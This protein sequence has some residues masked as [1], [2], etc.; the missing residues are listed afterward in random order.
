MTSSSDDIT[1]DDI[2]ELWWCVRFVVGLLSWRAHFPSPPRPVPGLLTGLPC[3]NAVVRRQVGVSCTMAF[4]SSFEPPERMSRVP[5]PTAPT[6]HPSTARPAGRQVPAEVDP[7]AHARAASQHHP[8]QQRHEHHHHHRSR[9]DQLQVAG[10]LPDVPPASSSA[11]AASQHGDAEPAPQPPPALPLGISSACRDADDEAGYTAAAALLARHWPDF[12]CEHLIL[13]ET[14]RKWNPLR[15]MHVSGTV[16]LS[17][18]ALCFLPDVGLAE[19]PLAL[20][21]LEAVSL[22]TSWLIYLSARLDFACHNSTSNT[23]E[24]SQ[25]SIELAA[26]QNPRVFLMVAVALAADVSFSRMRIANAVLPRLNKSKTQQLIREKIRSMLELIVQSRRQL[27]ADQARVSTMQQTTH[28]MNKQLSVGARFLAVMK[29]TL[30]QSFFPASLRDD[31]DRAIPVVAPQPSKSARAGRSTAMP[32]D[33]TLPHPTRLSAAAAAGAQDSPT[34]SAA[35]GQAHAQWSHSMLDRLVQA[36]PGALATVLDTKASVFPSPRVLRDFITTIADSLD[37]S[38]LIFPCLLRPVSSAHTAT[39]GLGWLVLDAAGKSIAFIDCVPANGH[40]PSVHII[41]SGSEPYSK[42]FVCSLAHGDT[43]L[44]FGS[45]QEPWLVMSPRA[46]SLYVTLTAH[47]S[48]V[49]DAGAARPEFL[50][51]VVEDLD[52]SRLGEVLLRMVY[53]EAVMLNRSLSSSND[54]LQNLVSS[55]DSTVLGL[56]AAHKSV[57]QQLGE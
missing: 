45:P 55:L 9:P 42:G 12:A 30:P 5:A 29:S 25:E 44:V 16:F 35:S 31:L 39:W 26:L 41:A 49:P 15:K 57:R 18:T 32:F 27:Q 6:P 46:H 43:R 28:A 20:I 4:S 38:I 52:W 11:Q 10:P 2:I 13:A 17:E 8:R 22:S 1:I 23:G 36:V 51:P 54:S 19:K 24:S 47:Y 14:C 50:N 7:S 37:E 3:G 56:S 53:A 48:A 21:D 40:V 33:D 34:L